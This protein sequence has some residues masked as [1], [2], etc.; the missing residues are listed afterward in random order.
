MILWSP[1]ALSRREELRIWSASLPAILGDETAR[2]WNGRPLTTF[3]RASA[4]FIYF[5]QGT[6]AAYEW[7]SEHAW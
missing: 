3:E 7:L 4:S 6:Q 2:Y 1:D 5:T